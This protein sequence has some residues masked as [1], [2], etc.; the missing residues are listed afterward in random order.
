MLVKGADYSLENIVGADSISPWAGQEFIEFLPG[1]STSAIGIL[2]E[3]PSV[4]K[5]K[6]FEQLIP[7]LHKNQYQGKDPIPALFLITRHL[8]GCESAGMLKSEKSVE[9]ELEGTWNLIPIPRTN[10]G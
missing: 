10:I 6:D 8:S 7:Y 5:V 3:K 4:R 2:T 1:Y 9:K